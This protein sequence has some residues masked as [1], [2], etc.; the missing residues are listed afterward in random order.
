MRV[1]FSCLYCKAVYHATQILKPSLVVGRF[2]CKGCNTTV[3]R[4][5]GTQYSY[6]GWTGPLDL[7]RPN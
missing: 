3:L 1:F 2:T 5:W 4:W 7:R 6:T